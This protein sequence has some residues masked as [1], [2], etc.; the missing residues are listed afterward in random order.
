[1]SLVACHRVGTSGKVVAFEPSPPLVQL[2]Q[3]HKKVNGFHQ[4]EI[5]SKAVADSGNRLV[6]FYLLDSG[7]SFLNSL[8]DH[9][10]DA[11]A[12]WTGRKSVMHVETITLDEFC[13][14]TNLHPNVVK[15]DIEGGELLAVHGCTGLLK[16]CRTAFI[17]AMHPTWL[18]KGQKAEELFDLFRVHGY[19]IRASQ[20]VQYEGADF[21]DY[22]F[23][24]DH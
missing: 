7:D 18:P 19:K 22:L 13:K 17:V 9:P 16:E 24:P 10:V 2:L 1:M 4:M 8:I 21:G 11:S 15:I 5:L 20:F 3:Y 6:P 12:S 23:V 14:M